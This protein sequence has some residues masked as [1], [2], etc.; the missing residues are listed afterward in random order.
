[1]ARFL[2]ATLLY[3]LQPLK[4]FDE[5]LAHL[6]VAEAAHLDSLESLLSCMSS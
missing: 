3:F 5:V 1:M 2:P 4:F 6:A